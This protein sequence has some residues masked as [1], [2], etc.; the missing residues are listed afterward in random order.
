[1]D[2]LV[3]LNRHC[4][5][6]AAPLL[7]MIATTAS[8]A[9]AADAPVLL[10]PDMDC[11]VKIDGSS[12]GHV[13]KGASRLTQV[14]IGQHLIEADSDVGGFHWEQV[15][16]LQN[17]NQ[18]VVQI[19]LQAIADAAMQKKAAADAA[20]KQQAAAADAA[21]KQQADQASKLI[22]RLTY[23]RREWNAKGTYREAQNMADC[24]IRYDYDLTLNI[25]AFDI[26]TRKATGSLSIDRN[27]SSQPTPGLG[28]DKSCD[29]LDLR[30]S[31]S[32]TKLS[33]TVTCNDGGDRCSL[34]GARLSCSGQCPTMTGDYSGRVG[35]IQTSSFWAIQFVML[36]DPYLPS[37]IHFIAK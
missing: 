24:Q 34:E 19:G 27:F 33:A 13:K 15:I 6:S 32:E 14:T 9:T 10:H 11:A 5:V 1:M 12:V 28:D 2:V 31:H 23:F 37:L 17:S 16:T 21:A 7:F 30:S 3:S 18:V 22:S 20:A 4:R 36:D 26:S 35:S 25:E 29:Y 8:P